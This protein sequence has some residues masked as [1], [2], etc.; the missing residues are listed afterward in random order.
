[1]G[2]IC[3]FCGSGAGDDSRHGELAAGTGRAI[4]ERG[5]RL[6][7]GGART[8]LMGLTARACL[9][10]GGEVLGIIPEFL[11]PIEG[12]QDGAEIRITATLGAR[13][14]M[15]IEEADAFLVLPGGLGTLEEVFDMM[16]LR[17][18][19]RHSKP[20]AFL[21][22]EYWSPLEGLIRHVVESGYAS[23]DSLDALSFHA[24]TQAALDALSSAVDAAA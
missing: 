6:V 1:M 11:I 2:S 16:M 21:D 5:W 18:L 19:G 17:Q 15:M 12:T 4:A 24:G 20:T 23:R 14:A 22:S 7:F 10:A 3:V 8:G 9:A 13:K